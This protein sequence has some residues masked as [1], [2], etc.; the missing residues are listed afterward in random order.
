MY[1]YNKK[2][3]TKEF[4]NQIIIQHN[5]SLINER[6][7]YMFT[8]LQEKGMHEIFVYKLSSRRRQS[9]ETETIEKEKTKTEREG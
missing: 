2:K 5:S 1:T 6:E 9:V 4:S 8:C 7:K 3:Q